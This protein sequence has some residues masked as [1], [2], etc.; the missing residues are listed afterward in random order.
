MFGPGPNCFRSYKFR[1]GSGL[2]PPFDLCEV[3]GRLAAHPVAKGATRVGATSFWAWPE[4]L[5]VVKFKI[6]VGGGPSL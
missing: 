3:G 5:S 1:S 4:L 6:G 2:V